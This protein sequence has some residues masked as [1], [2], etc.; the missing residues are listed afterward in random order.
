MVPRTALLFIAVALGACGDDTALQGVV[1]D[2]VL[3]PDDRESVTLVNHDPVEADLGG[4][5]IADDDGQQWRLPPS[6]KIPAGDSLTVRVGPGTTSPSEL[7]L[8]AEPMLDSG[9]TI[10]LLDSAGAE[11]HRTD[12]D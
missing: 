8:D 4:W 12:V 3:T 10:R 2:T 6:T 9:D 7:H 1:I 11:V 5:S